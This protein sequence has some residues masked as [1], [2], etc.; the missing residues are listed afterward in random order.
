M[1]DGYK[2]W[3]S[4]HGEEQARA[5]R[6]KPRR[7]DRWKPTDPAAS[8]HKTKERGKGGDGQ[9]GAVKESRGRS[10]FRMKPN[11][12]PSGAGHGQEK[13]YGPSPGG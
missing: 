13:A 11:G 1:K 8:A 2:G 3:P 7:G 6:V 10:S 12:A 9:A 5:R 4:Q